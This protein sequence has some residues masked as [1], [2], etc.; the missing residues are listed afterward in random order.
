MRTDLLIF[1]LKRLICDA[2]HS[3]RLNACSLCACILLYYMFLVFHWTVMNVSVPHAWAL[4]PC[5]LFSLFRSLA[6]SS[7]GRDLGLPV[8]MMIMN[9]NVLTVPV[10]RCTP[11]P[12]CYRLRLLRLGKPEIKECEFTSNHLWLRYDTVCEQEIEIEFR[13]IQGFAS[14]HR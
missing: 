1:F 3:H 2:S 11:L 4:W 10:L 14:L 5:F 6:S 7:S 8:W 13:F 12:P 9:L